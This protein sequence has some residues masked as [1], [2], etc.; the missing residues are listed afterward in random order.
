MSEKVHMEARTSEIL[1]QVFEV[2]PLVQEHHAPGSALYDLLKQ[3]VRPEVER[4]FGGKDVCEID[5][6]PFG[7]LKF[8]YHEMGAVNSLNLFDLDECILFSFY[9]LNRHRY[10]KVVDIGA[11]LGLHTILLRFCGYE[12]SCYEPDPV[13]F[14]ILQQNL[15]LNGVSDVRAVNAAVSTGAGETEF[16]RVVGN[17]T[18]SHLAGSKPNPYGQ[19]ERFPVRTVAFKPLLRKAD[20]V[21]LDVEG[22]EKDLI[23]D[24]TGQDWE[25]T[26]AL[27]EIESEE[28]A[29]AVFQHLAGQGVRM[30]PQKRNWQLAASVEDL[31]TSYKQGMLFVTRTDSMPWQ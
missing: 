16:V 2:L 25:T 29:R 15:K 21:K 19:L 9:R 11:N 20:L 12:V 18:G 24:T 22:H 26:D 3:V 30:F 6:K 5:F 23:L 31:P 27:V 17:T 14:G 28:N 13:H 10:H 1:P 8:P 4:L 7:L